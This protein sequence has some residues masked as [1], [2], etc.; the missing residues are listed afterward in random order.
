TGTAHTRRAKSQTL[1][2]PSGAPA[3]RAAAAGAITPGWVALP[4]ASTTSPR[5]TTSPT[6][7][8]SSSAPTQGLTDERHSPT[9]RPPRPPAA[10][11][12]R[13]GA[14]P[15]QPAQRR[16][17]RDDLPAAAR[18]PARRAARQPL[19]PRRHRG[20]GRVRRQPS[21][22]LVRRAVGPGRPA[23][24]LRAA[25]LL[26]GGAGPPAPRRRRRALAALRPPRRGPPR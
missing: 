7:A 1:E 20:G 2:H 18:L 12:Q 6:A 24:G 15:G 26:A 25:G 8:D 21:Q 16:R 11:P 10:A 5:A 17:Q 23:Q 13:Q 4:R 22:A 3:F 19:L 9:P 14:R